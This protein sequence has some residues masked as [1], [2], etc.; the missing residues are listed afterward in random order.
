MKPQSTQMN[1]DLPITMSGEEPHNRLFGNEWKYVREVLAEEFRTSSGA[2]MMRRLESAF[3]EKFGSAYAISHVNGT[4]TM[5]SILEAAGIGAGDEVIVPP[6]TMASTTH[7]VLQANATPIYADVDPETFLISPQSIR[8]RLTPKTRAIITVALYGLSPDMD[9]IMEIARRHNLLVIED[10]AECFLGKYNGRLAGTLGH[11]ASF[12]FQS[13]KHMTSG[14]GG[15]VV[16][17]DAEL[18]EKVRMVCTLGYRGVGAKTAKLK[19]T[20]IQDPDYARHASM[21][22]NYRLP[23]LCAAVALGQL[24]NLDEL[25]RRRTEAAGLLHAAVAGCPWLTPQKTPANCVHSWW[26]YVVALDTQRIA[27]RTFRDAFLANGGDGI[28]AAWKI[29]YLEPMFQERKLLGR[30]RFISPDHLAC[31]RP[32]LCPVAEQVQP[33]LLQFK[34]NY[35]DIREAQRQAEILAATIRKLS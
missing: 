18:A 11:A 7:V 14:E 22:W 19:R 9:P 32:G 6:L 15:M 26:T 10:N 20:D 35:W 27:W 24:E 16:T 4:A 17:D 21:G 2:T 3:A 5:H 34:T 29:N 8:Q 28:Y 30:E 13:S 12:S 33:R 23:E 31:Y 1:T 25:V